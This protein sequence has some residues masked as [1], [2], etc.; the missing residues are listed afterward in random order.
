MFYLSGVKE[1]GIYWVLNCV[2]ISLFLNYI[3]FTYLSLNTNW[4]GN[5]IGTDSI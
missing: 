3:D 1:V 2:D 5:W 4:I